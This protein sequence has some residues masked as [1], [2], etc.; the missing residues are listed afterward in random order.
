[1][2]GHS[3]EQTFT[4]N[5]T[6]DLQHP[7]KARHSTTFLAL[8]VTVTIATLSSLPWLPHWLEQRHGYSNAAKNLNELHNT[9]PGL[10]LIL[11]FNTSHTSTN[12]QTHAHM[13]TNARSDGMWRQIFTASVADICT[14]LVPEGTTLIM[15]GTS[16]ETRLIYKWHLL[17]MS[18][19]M[20]THMH[21][22][23]H[24]YTAC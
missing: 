5:S 4:R 24:I 10:N 21:R 14:V 17:K 19:L 7:W 23:T 18:S 22:D 12:T 2:S 3:N 9:L 8:P 15:A 16:L 6:T 13:H 11:P 1:M 20:N